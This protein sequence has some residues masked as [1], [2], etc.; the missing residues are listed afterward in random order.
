[1]F[2][3]PQSLTT[4]TL[5]ARDISRRAPRAGPWLLRGASIIVRPGD[6]IGVHGESGSGKTVLLRA[7]AA[8]DPIDSGLL[9]WSGEK[10]AGHFVPVYRS[11]VTYLHQRP[12]VFEGTVE[13]NLRLPFGL[14]VHEAKRFHHDRARALLDAFGKPDSFLQKLQGD[15]SGGEAQIVALVRALLLDPAVLLLDEPTAS[16]DA[17]SVTM[18]ERHIRGWLD[19]A[20]AARAV[21]CVSHDLELVS[22]FTE[23]RLGM[24]DGSLAEGA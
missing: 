19:E 14:R 6:R 18:V 23:R 20:P 17:R 15:L 12:V 21:V 24:R 16:L 13:H 8:L 22:R 2:S 3:R 4:W 10:V 11:R 5:E 7:I 1:M 9:R